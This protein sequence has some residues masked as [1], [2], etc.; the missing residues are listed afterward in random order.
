MAD[1]QDSLKYPIGRFSV[2]D[3]I[4]EENIEQWISEIESFP[5]ELEGALAQVTE[6]QLNTPYRPDGWTIRQ[7]VHHVADSHL[8]SYIRFKWAMTEK[9][10]TIK[11]YD[12]NVW[13]QLEDSKNAPVEVSVAMIKGIHSRWVVFLRTLS[14]DDLSRT[15]FHPEYNRS[16]RLDR[17]V[18][19]YAWH[20]KHHLGHVRIVLSTKY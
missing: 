2:P 17:N 8:N 4:T 18:A 14:M 20:G 12:E 6:E 15:F 9:N 1:N 11:G 7:V 16:I 10:P 5:S 13:A 19:L 3:S